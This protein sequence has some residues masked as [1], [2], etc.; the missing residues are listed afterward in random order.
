[1]TTTAMMMMIVMEKNENG[2]TKK[3]A[4]NAKTEKKWNK[5]KRERNNE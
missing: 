1:M 4:M 2:K 5:M 3:N